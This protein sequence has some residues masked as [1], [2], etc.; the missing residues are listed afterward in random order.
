MTYQLTKSDT[1]YE[2]DD[3][4]FFD[5][6]PKAFRAAFNELRQGDTA[7]FDNA[8]V[9]LLATGR[10][11]I[12]PLPASPNGEEQEQINEKMNIN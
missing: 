1:T 4:V 3:T 5:N 12:T 11:I 10:V 9:T 8:M 7:E 2:V 6:Q